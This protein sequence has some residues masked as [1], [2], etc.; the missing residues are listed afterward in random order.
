[1]HPQSL[2]DIGAAAFSILRHVQCTEH[3]PRS[4]LSDATH[5]RR[6]Q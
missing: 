5:T 3:R 6:T 2:S 1:M 4:S